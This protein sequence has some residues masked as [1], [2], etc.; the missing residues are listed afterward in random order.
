MEENMDELIH[1]ELTEL[2]K[3]QKKSGKDMQHTLKRSLEVSENVIKEL[4]ALQDKKMSID[5]NHVER[6]LNE[7]KNLKV[8]SPDLREARSLVNRLSWKKTVPHWIVVAMSALFISN[9]V[10]ALYSHKMHRKA[11][12]AQEHRDYLIEFVHHS[13]VSENEFYNWYGDADTT[14]GYRPVMIIPNYV[15]YKFKWYKEWFGE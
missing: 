11:K 10:F 13:K 15:D 8:P 7:F 6:C 3:M 1:H 14:G 2:R 12:L 9:M 5:I 4:K